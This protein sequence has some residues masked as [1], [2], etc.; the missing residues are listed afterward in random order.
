M[1]VPA[2]AGRAPDVPPAAVTVELVADL[3]GDQL[4]RAALRRGQAA[5]LVGRLLH[6]PTLAGERARRVAAAAG[7]ELAPAYW[8]AVVACA[9]DPPPPDLADHLD[10]ELAGAV[11]GALCALVDDQ[12]VLLH[13]DGDGGPPP[14]RCFERIAASVRRR[15]PATRARVYAAHTPA[16][17]GELAA[18]VTQLARLGRRDAESGGGPPV[19]IARRYELDRL[20]C[21][22][23]A[24]ADARGFV[25]DRLGAL[26]AWDRD[27]RT[28]L[29]RV[30][31]AALDFPRHE[32]AARRCF[33]HRNTFRHRFRQAAE[34]L[35]GDLDDPDARLAVHV[36]LKLRRALPAGGA[37]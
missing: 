7:V 28:D 5:A 24:P 8:P 36:A 11:P 31:E 3:L 22:S 37:G 35:G 29:L 17:P 12:L 32:Q 4:A 34:L 18:Q 21:E 33:M 14:V 15:A 19:V 26:I 16:A 20:L 6:D 1:A 13:P 23:L 10:R 30:L 25:E 27:H 2:A 9:G